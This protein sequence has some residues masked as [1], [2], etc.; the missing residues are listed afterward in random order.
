MVV[1][2]NLDCDW[3][4]IEKTLLFVYIKGRRGDFMKWTNERI[5]KYV[6]FGF[7]GLVISLIVGAATIVLSPLALLY[8]VGYLI[9][10][11]YLFVIYLKN[12]PDEAKESLRQM[13]EYFS[14]PQ[15]VRAS[16]TRHNRKIAAKRRKKQIKRRKRQARNL[17]L[18]HAANKSIREVMK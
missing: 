4:F 8:A 2:K 15:V 16:R 11:L 13:V 5:T 3:I 10:L 1:Y 17:I 12:R 6:L 14:E 7:I 9:M 18:L